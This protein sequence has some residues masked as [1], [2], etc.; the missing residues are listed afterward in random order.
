M[1]VGPLA[2]TSPFAIM[3]SGTPVSVE[4]APAV[5][6]SN[7]PNFLRRATKRGTKGGGK[8]GKGKR[9][10]KETRI[11]SA[12]NSE[13]NGVALTTITAIRVDVPRGGEDEDPLLAAGV[14]SDA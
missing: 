5:W 8:K 11:R 9:K 10:E 12:S 14:G 2:L 4:I 3:P 13:E 1:V 6:S 7:N